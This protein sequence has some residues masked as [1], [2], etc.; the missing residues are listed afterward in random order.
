[1]PKLDGTGPTSQGAG[2]GRGMGK[3]GAG[4]MH[5]SCC[6]RLGGMGRRFYSSKNDLSSLLDDQQFLKDELV[7]IE[8]KIKVAKA[9]E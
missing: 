1:M 5:R 8:E 9:Q 7:S 4:E 2:S 3:C 6:G